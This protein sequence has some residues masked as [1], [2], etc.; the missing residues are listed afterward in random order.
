MLRATHLFLFTNQTLKSNTISFEKLKICSSPKR[1][2]TISHMIT[3]F[4]SFRE[5]KKGF[6]GIDVGIYR[7]G[8]VSTAS[9]ACSTNHHLR[10][11]F[12]A[13]AFQASMPFTRRHCGTFLLE[14]FEFRFVLFIFAIASVLLR[15]SSIHGDQ[16]RQHLEHWVDNEW[17]PPSVN[18]HRL[19]YSSSSHILIHSIAH[20]IQTTPKNDIPHLSQHFLPHKPPTCSIL[21]L[22]PFASGAC[23]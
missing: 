21:L 14:D 13:S 4:F 9:S 18:N 22:R 23:P 1:H 19:S 12:Q 10:L 2:P 8:G 6:E 3:N 20:Q 15:R 7:I 11:P 17:L 16:Y 5:I